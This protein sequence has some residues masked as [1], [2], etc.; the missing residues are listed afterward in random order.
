MKGADTIMSKDNDEDPFDPFPGEFS[1]SGR[2]PLELPGLMD[3]NLSKPNEFDLD[4]FRRG[5]G[6]QTSNPRAAP[7]QAAGSQTPRLTGSD[8]RA[9]RHATGE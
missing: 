7:E 4:R 6:G 5:S 9:L 3:P 1:V 8:A 2:D